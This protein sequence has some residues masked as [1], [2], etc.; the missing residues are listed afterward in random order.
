MTLL[1]KFGIG[2]IDYNNSNVFILS[3][4][5]GLVFVRCMIDAKQKVNSNIGV[6]IFG[7]KT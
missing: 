1:M 4:E 3:L 6:I 7:F 2:K 5:S